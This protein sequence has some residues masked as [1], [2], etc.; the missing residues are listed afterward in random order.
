MERLSFSLRCTLIVDLINK[1]RERGSSWCGE[2]HVQK[3]MY[4]T[5]D[6]AR[7]NLRYKFIM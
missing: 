7:I 2:T 4:I 5:E 3:A 1:L 6:L